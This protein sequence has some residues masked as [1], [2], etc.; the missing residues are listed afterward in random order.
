MLYVNCKM[1]TYIVNKSTNYVIDQ[2]ALGCKWPQM[3]MSGCD[4]CID[5]FVL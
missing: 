4:K 3:M 2:T 1:Y 5:K